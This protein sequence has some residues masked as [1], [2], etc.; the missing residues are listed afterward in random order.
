MHSP[1]SL[2]KIKNIQFTLTQIKSLGVI[3][4]I[5]STREKLYKLKINNSSE[6]HERIEVTGQM[7]PQKTGVCRNLSSLR[8]EAVAARDCQEDKH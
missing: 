8:V 4:P 6:I 2:N 7:S 1:S 3:A 5:L